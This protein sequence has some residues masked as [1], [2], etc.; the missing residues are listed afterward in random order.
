MTLR[1]ATFIVA[2]AAALAGCASTRSDHS[3]SAPMAEIDKSI[4]DV[5]AS[6]TQANHSIAQVEVARSRPVDL[7]QSQSNV[8]LPADAVQ[9]VTVQWSGGL[10]P[11]LADIARRAGYNFRVIGTRPAAEIIVNIVAA[12]EPLFGVVRRAGNLA[13]G[14]ADIAFNPTAK[15]IEL[16][17]R[18]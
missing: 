5:V 10:E 6:S 11:F 7:S 12:E 1:K 9:P 13:H 15:L 18:S 14:S 17:Y 2:A 4:S 8:V 16:R 3:L